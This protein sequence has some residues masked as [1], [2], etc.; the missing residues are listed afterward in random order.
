MAHAAR[1]VCDVEMCFDTPAKGELMC[2]G[3]IRAA[4]QRKG[5]GK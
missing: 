3:H 4:Q 5:L 2:R 1:S